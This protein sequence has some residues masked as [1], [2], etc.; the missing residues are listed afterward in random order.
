M[1]VDIDL[2][3]LDRRFSA[4]PVNLEGDDLAT[5]F[6]PQPSTVMVEVSGPREL[7]KTLQPGNIQVIAKVDED[8]EGKLVP[9]D[10]DLPTG[11]TLNL[12]EPLQVKV[13]RAGPIAELAKKKK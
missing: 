7:I 1:N 4:I 11:V 12:V 5:K 2:V 3:I 8:A 13:M 9:I 6:K 10:V